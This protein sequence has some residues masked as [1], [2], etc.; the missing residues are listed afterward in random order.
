MD[1]KGFRTGLEE[2]CHFREDEDIVTTH[3]REEE[4]KKYTNRKFEEFTR[5]METIEEK[6]KEI[7]ESEFHV[8]LHEK[9]RK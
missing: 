3:K 5:Y 1:I 2:F 9:W 4:K 7:L 6:V 8:K